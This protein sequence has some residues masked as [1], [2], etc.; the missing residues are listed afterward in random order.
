MQA[1]MALAV[2]LAA[3]SFA[4]AEPLPWD[5]EKVT[6][7]A[8]ELPPDTRALRESVRRQPP[9]TLGQAGK[10]AFWRLHDQLR[11]IE[12]TSRRLHNAL[13]A[14]EGHEETF[15]STAG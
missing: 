3:A 13:L 14:G 2:S 7:I 9:P 8:A 1:C 10:R 15:P 12:S 4:T 5:Q 11:S 6:E